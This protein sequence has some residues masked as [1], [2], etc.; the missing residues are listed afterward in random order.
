MSTPS[1]FRVQHI[2]ALIIVLL[3][4]VSATVSGH[5]Q[6]QKKFSFSQGAMPLGDALESFSLTTHLD[7]AASSDTVRGKTA[8]ALN[9]SLTANE[10]LG[11]LLA[12]TGLSFRFSD[13]RTIVIV[14]PKPSGAAEGGDSSTDLPPVI[15]TAGGVVGYSAPEATETTKIGLPAFE[16]PFAIQAV[17][18]NVVDDQKSTRLEEVLRNVSAVGKSGSDTNGL[19]DVLTVRGFPLSNYGQTYRDGFRLRVPQVNL[20][21]METVEVLKGASG[22]LYGRIE[23]GGLVNLVTK[24]PLDEPYYSLEQ[25]IGSYN[26]THTIGDATGPLNPENTLRYRLVAGYEE[27]DTFR[28][29]PYSRLLIAPSLSWDIT[30]ETQFNLSMEYKKNEDTLNGTLVAKGDRPA[31]IPSDRLIGVTGLPT[32]PSEHWLVD[33]SISHEVTDQWKVKLRGVWWNW[34]ADYYDVGPNDGVNPDGRTVDLYHFTSDEEDTTWFGELSL[35]GKFDTGSLKHDLLM[36]VEYYSFES[37]QR[38]YFSF[39]P[40]IPIRPLDIFNPRYQAYSSLPTPHTQDLNNPK[41]SWWGFSVQDLITVNDRFKLLLS[42]RYDLTDASTY[43]DGDITSSTNAIDRQFQDEGRFTPRIGLNYEL[44]PWLSVF[45][46]Y[47]ESFSDSTFGT[48]KDGSPTEPQS[49]TQYEVGLKGRWMD[50]RINATLAFFHLTK[51]NLTTDIPNSIFVTQ[52]GEARSRGV[53][54]DVAG[55]VTEHLSLIASYAYLDTEITEDTFNQGNRLPNAPEHSGSIWAK[56]EFPNGFAIG[57]GLTAVG[58]RQGDLDNS[59]L[60]ESYIRADVMAAYRFTVGK[61]RMTAQL[62]INNLFDEDYYDGTGGSSRTYIYA[63][64]PRTFIGSLRIEF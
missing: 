48:L 33:A 58:D 23:P 50:G 62:N 1:V 44:Q 40:D 3:T 51:E 5:A 16:S 49:A 38:N 54:L 47:A 32:S 43:Y 7:I 36:S 18:R 46:S 22:G 59:F 9:G 55:Q 2:R 13:A 30:P 17:P 34:T 29:S 57:A 19:Y 10:A 27:S 42:G 45:G 4:I 41:D 61:T 28:D 12:G 53:E 11:K 25:Q 24:K 26:F 56:Y 31:N 21:N 6:D 15:V 14:A 60:L 37:T 20:D 52:S 35:E 64:E 39:A 63:G 8:P